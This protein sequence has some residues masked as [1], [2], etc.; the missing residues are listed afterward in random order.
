[1]ESQRIWNAPRRWADPTTGQMRRKRQ[2]VAREGATVRLRWRR[3][4]KQR[5]FIARQAPAFQSR[6]CPLVT[7]QQF[8]ASQGIGTPL[9]WRRPM[10]QQQSIAWQAPAFQSRRRPSVTQPQFIVSQGTGGRLRLRRPM[11]QRLSDVSRGHQ[12]RRRSLWNT[13]TQVPK[14]IRTFRKTRFGSKV[15]RRAGCQCRT[16]RTNGRM[17]HSQGRGQRG[18][19]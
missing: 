19:Q 11:T 12:C 5:Q 14:H 3:P 2:S 8:I 18:H 4:M 9:R 7:Q 10:K 6:R 13:R 16:S 17:A 15:R 1:M